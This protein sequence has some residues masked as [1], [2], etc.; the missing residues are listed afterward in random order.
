MRPPSPTP[1]ATATPTACTLQP[2]DVP[3]DNTF[4]LFVRCLACQ[5]IISG[6]ECGGTGEPCNPNNDPYFRPNNYVTCGQLAK[7]VSELGGL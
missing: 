2:A 7:I 6:Y 3:T 4:Y 5:G 1:P